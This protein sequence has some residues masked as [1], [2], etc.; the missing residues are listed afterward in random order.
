MNKGYWNVQ[1]D[2]KSALGNDTK[3][4]RGADDSDD[5]EGSASN[6]MMRTHNNA[7][8]EY[9][10]GQQVVYDDYLLTA[11]NHS[12]GTLMLLRC[13]LEGIHLQ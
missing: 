8:M 11:V 7:P 2:C 4:R 9:M 13:H 6:V 5:G 3:K 10:G 12:P 1:C